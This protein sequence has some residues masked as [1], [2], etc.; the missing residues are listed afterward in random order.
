M[1]HPTA[2]IHPGAQ[3]HESVRVG[4]YSVIDEHVMVGAGCELAP[5]VHLTGHTT[6]GAE[7]RFHTGSVIGDAP[8]DLKYDGE[9]TWLIIG[10]RNRFRAHV[11][12][13]RSTTPG[14]ATKIGT[15]KY[16]MANSHVGH[17]SII[18]NKVILAN[19]VLI[20][21]H[22]M[23][24]E[25]AFIAGNA[26]VHQFCRVGT[27]AMMQGCAGVSLDLPP[28]TIV[29]GINGMCGLNS[30]GLKRAGFSAKE[31]SQLKKAYH[32]IFLYDDLLKDALEKARDEFT[33]V[34]AEQLIDFVATSQRGT[35]SHT[36][37]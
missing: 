31:R 22:V 30:V 27:M 18:G 3:L 10:A 28:F 2:I 35:C 5:H 24:G 26:V 23:I 12:V 34:L 14:E 29:R 11:T 15:E 9:T 36:K 25:G 13:P 1:I 32:A 4:P 6:I 21:G 17:N 19:G 7:N 33:G 20:A 16:F 37:R 8:Q